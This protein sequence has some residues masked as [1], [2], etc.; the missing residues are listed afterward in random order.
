[1]HVWADAAYT[2]QLARWAAEPMGWEVKIVTWSDVLRGIVVQAHCRL[3]EQSKRRGA[4]C[5][6]FKT[7]L[8]QPSRTR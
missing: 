6:F 4:R 5:P 7:A 3:A 1:M 8:S 2:G